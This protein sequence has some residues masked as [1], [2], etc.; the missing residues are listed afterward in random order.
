[1]KN[2]KYRRRKHQALFL[3]FSFCI[4]PFLPLPDPHRP[5]AGAG[6]EDCAGRII[7]EVGDGVGVRG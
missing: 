6:G 1:M 4:F 5:V 2:E 3:H 7:G